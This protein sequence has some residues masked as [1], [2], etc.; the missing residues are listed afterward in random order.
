[1]RRFFLTIHLAAGLVAGAFMVMLGSTG[2]II[3]FEPELDRLFHPHLSHVTPGARTLSLAEIGAA[4]SGKYGDEP[5][6]AFLPSTSAH[7][8]AEVIISR[9]IVS[10]NQYTGEILGLR[11][12]GQTFLGFVRALHVRLAS[13]DIGK[14]IVTWSTVAML[15]SL[16][17]GLYL[18]WPA[19]RVRI[20]KPWGSKAFL[21]DLHNAI[22]IFALMPFLLLAA[23]G[24]VLGFERG[25]ASL[26]DRVADKPVVHVNKTAA[27]SQHEPG[28]VQVTPDNAVEIACARIPG[29]LAYRVQMPRFGGRYQVSLV[30]LGDRVL[31]ERNSI[32]VDPWSGKVLS[33]D[34]ANDLS[35]RERAMAWNESIHTGTAFGMTSR[36]IVA[37]AGILLP[38]QAVSGL[39]IWLR[40]RKF[41]NSSK[42]E[43]ALP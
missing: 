20:R 30:K 28:A 7:V 10:V 24:A 14:E 8:P 11:T 18:W 12:R 43:C 4:V 15:L 16:I 23:T 26:L 21:Y 33:A 6:V 5:I 42:S 17:S 32:S 38:V 22:G 2:S 37:T 40:R 39:L 36:I 34:R 3:A 9:G 41:M 27:G 29:A 31:G 35:R 13:G 1:V 19:K 25:A